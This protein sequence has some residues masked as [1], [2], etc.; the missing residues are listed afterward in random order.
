MPQAYWDTTYSH[1]HAL[2]QEGSSYMYGVED[3]LL[4]SLIC[5]V[6]LPFPVSS[7]SEKS[8]ISLPVVAA[9]AGTVGCLLLLIAGV[10]TLICIFRSRHRRPGGLS[11]TASERDERERERDDQLHMFFRSSNQHRRHEDLQCPP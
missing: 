6:S 2:R 3:T 1:T 5:D 7:G 8:G 11:R 4:L 10:L 9:V